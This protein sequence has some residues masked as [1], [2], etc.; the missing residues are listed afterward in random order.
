[1]R[2]RSQQIH[3]GSSNEFKNIYIIPSMENET[4][5]V[6]MIPNKPGAITKSLMH[7]SI[8]DGLKNFQEKTSNFEQRSIWL[9]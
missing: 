4:N 1:M 9:P 3:E 8:N 7:E 2:I 6:I 5:L